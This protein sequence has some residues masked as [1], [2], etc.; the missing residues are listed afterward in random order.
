ME[1]KLQIL[2]SNDT[3]PSASYPAV[4][5]T[6]YEANSYLKVHSGEFLPPGV[7]T[8]LLSVQ[9]E[10]ATASADVDFDKL[11]RSYPNPND[12]GTEDP[13]GD[14]SWDTTRDGDGQNPIRKCRGPGA[15]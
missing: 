6:E 8:P 3:Q 14:V 7:R 4:I 11:S 5:I 15:D 10:H 13:G 12:M 1:A 2:E 9:P